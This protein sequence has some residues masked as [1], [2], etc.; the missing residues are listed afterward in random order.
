MTKRTFNDFLRSRRLR[1]DAGSDFF[2]FA[3]V[4]RPLPEIQAWGE[5]RA[6]LNEAGAPHEVMV[7]GRAIW[8]HYKLDQS[9]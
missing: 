2:E 6:Y 5:L 8:R 7:A 9:S 3:K 1:N 4:H